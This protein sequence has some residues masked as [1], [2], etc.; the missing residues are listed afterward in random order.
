ML[1]GRALMTLVISVLVLAAG[2][3]AVAASELQP[4]ELEELR[5]VG[6]VSGTDDPMA[7]LEGPRGEPYTLVVGTLIGRRWSKV[8]RIKDRCVDLEE[9]S[10]DPQGRITV[11]PL[12]L[13]LDRSATSGG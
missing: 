6:I 9:I 13:C 8:V 3:V 1:A 11:H 4:Y 12:R 7:L 2:R 5:L 10:R